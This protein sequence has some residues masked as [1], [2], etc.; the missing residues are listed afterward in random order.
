[1]KREYAS[2]NLVEP[3]N[4]N[5]GILSVVDGPARTGEDGSANL[6][7]LT[8]FQGVSPDSVLATPA[9]QSNP[10]DGVVSLHA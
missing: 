5:Q 4:F 9:I 3:P 8:I 7:A 2:A 10:L 1:M 6:S